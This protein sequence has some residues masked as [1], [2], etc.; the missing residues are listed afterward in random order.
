ML[1]IVMMNTIMADATFEGL[2]LFHLGYTRK[3]RWVEILCI[4]KCM[5][6]TSETTFHGK[7]TLLLVGRSMNWSETPYFHKG[8]QIVPKLPLSA[9]M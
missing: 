5:L 6:G 3:N 1:I 4:P 7:T 8:D 9:K 2:T